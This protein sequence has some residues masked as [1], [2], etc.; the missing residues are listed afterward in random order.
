MI[1]HIICY[2][3]MI[4]RE[5]HNSTYNM[6]FHH[7]IQ[8]D[9]RITGVLIIL[10]LHLTATIHHLTTAVHV[11][12]QSGTSHLTVQTSITCVTHHDDIHTDTDIPILQLTI[13]FQSHSRSPNPISISLISCRSESS[14]ICLVIYRLCRIEC[15]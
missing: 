10:L 8:H 6:F 9:H 3:I 1:Q 14:F 11:L 12:L 2:S 15:I 5:E 4:Q 7:M 13:Q